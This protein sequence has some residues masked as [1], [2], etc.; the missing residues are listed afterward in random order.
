MVSSS[1]YNPAPAD[2]PLRYPGRIPERVV[3]SYI[4]EP[5][6]VLNLL[7]HRGGKDV[8]KDYSGE[9]NH[10]TIHGAK[11]T[12][13]EIASWALDFD[14]VD[15]RIDVDDGYYSQPHTIVVWAKNVNSSVADEIAYD[16]GSWRLGI[17]NDSGFWTD[18]GFYVYN[19]TSYTV[20]TTDVDTS[21]WH[22]YGAVIDSG[23]NME[24]WVDGIS[25]GT[26][27]ETLDTT[28]MDLQ[29]VGA[30]GDGTHLNWNGL[31]G[32]V[33]IYDRVLT[34]SEVKDYYEKT[35]VLYGV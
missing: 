9:G 31:T 10:G 3:P 7:M 12:D 15:D 2:A 4:N 17:G 25:E 14:G 23:G 11:W 5:G 21:F 27:K 35:R 28:N 29:A 6:L 33:C 13:K 16:K 1:W 19:G 22:F 20:I 26:A 18:L 32:I 30:A 24:F 34:E 8:A